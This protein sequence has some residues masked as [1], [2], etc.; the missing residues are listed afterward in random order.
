MISTGFPSLPKRVRPLGAARL[1][2]SLLHKA[3]DPGKSPLVS[4]HSHP[5][6]KTEEEGANEAWDL[7]L[8][9]WGF[10]GQIK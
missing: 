8:P 10:G 3:E 7:E 2:L 4:D 9:Y 6:L 5:P 1:L